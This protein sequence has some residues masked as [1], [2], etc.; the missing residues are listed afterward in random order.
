M[1]VTLNHHSKRELKK[2]GVI[3]VLTVGEYTNI[4]FDYIKFDYTSK[5]VKG[6]EF[7]NVTILGF[8]CP[9]C[10]C[11]TSEEDMRKQPAKW[12]AENPEAYENGHRSFWLNAFTS[13]WTPWQRIVKKIP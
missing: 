10:G 4:V 8:A 6:K 9:H 13:P 2:D 5:I 1:Q 7:Y 3:N 12:I 11:I